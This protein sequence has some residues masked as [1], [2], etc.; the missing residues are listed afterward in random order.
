MDRNDKKNN[1]FEYLCKG[2]QGNLY[3][4]KQDLQTARDNFIQIG[5]F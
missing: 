4:H 1:N 2:L 5:C 3:P